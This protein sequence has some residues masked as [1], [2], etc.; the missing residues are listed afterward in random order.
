MDFYVM[1]SRAR[2]YLCFLYACDSGERPGI[3]QHFPE[4]GEGILEWKNA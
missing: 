4:P 2:E 3:L 1:A